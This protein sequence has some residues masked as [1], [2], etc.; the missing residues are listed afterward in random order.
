MNKFFKVIFLS[1]IFSI[2]Y[3]ANAGL[4]NLTSGTELG[5]MGNSKEYSTGITGL[6]LVVSTN[7]Y[8]YDDGSAG[9]G[10]CKSSIGT[11]CGSDDNLGTDGEWMNFTFMYNGNTVTEAFDLTFMVGDSHGGGLDNNG[12]TM[13]DVSTGL[14]NSSWN[15]TNA[16]PTETFNGNSFTFDPTLGQVY[17][18]SVRFEDDV[19]TQCFP[20]GCPDIP[21]PSN[22]AVL[23]FILIGLI[24]SRKFRRS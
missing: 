20:D 24:G 21:E 7:Y 13:M 23:A 17:F 10:V 22:I 3:S 2:S 14:A 6:V 16:S 11:G 9:L 5:V 12:G 8:L 15:P 4:I 1:L 18:L 19:N